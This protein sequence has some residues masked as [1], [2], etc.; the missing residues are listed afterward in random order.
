MFHDKIDRIFSQ[1]ALK[2]IYTRKPGFNSKQREKNKV[3]HGYINKESEHMVLTLTSGENINFL[4]N[5]LDNA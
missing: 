4:M 1:S 3:G 2:K 5:G